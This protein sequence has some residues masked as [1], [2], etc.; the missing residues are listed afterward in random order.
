M[1]PLDLFKY[2]PKCGSP[3]FVENN[4]IDINTPEFFIK[5]KEKWG[6]K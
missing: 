5:W 4:E 6:M 3:A 2:C 1:H